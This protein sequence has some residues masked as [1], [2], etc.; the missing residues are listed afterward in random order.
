MRD[1]H[2]RDSANHV[3]GHRQFPANPVERT[4]GQPRVGVRVVAHGVAG[5]DDRPRNAGMPPHILSA[6]EERCLDVQ[7]LQQL[8]EPFGI[9]SRSVVECQGDFPAPRGQAPHASPPA[10]RGGPCR[11]VRCVSQGDG[12]NDCRKP[13]R[14]DLSGSPTRCAVAKVPLPPAGRERPAQLRLISGISRP[15]PASAIYW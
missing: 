9:P 12:R 7:P 8:E 13:H 10:P 14:P 15:R 2:S 1:G 6:H 5:Q 4:A 11:R 3:L